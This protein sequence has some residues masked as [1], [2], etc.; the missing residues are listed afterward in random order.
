MLSCCRPDVGSNPTCTRMMR[1]QKVREDRDSL[2]KLCTCCKKTRP[3]E[4]FN[5]RRK[6]TLVRAVNTASYC[7]SCHSSK[8]AEQRD[9]WRKVALDSLGGK[10]SC[11]E[12]DYTVL[13]IDHIHGDGHNHRIVNRYIVPRTY[14]YYRKIA[15]DESRSEEYQALCANCHVRKTRANGE[16]YQGVRH[17]V[18]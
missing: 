1:G 6:N 9:E 14:V 10:C 5:L 15:S 2:M 16:Y 18:R 12:S 8:L 4:N 13:Q 17:A 7:R 11:G 3:I